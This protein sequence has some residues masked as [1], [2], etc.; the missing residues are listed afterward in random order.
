MREALALL[1]GDPEVEAYAWFT[2]DNS[3]WAWL[4]ALCGAYCGLTAGGGQK[5]LAA[6]P[7]GVPAQSGMK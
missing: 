7:G 5:G 2:V 3:K 4:G 1:D 6:E